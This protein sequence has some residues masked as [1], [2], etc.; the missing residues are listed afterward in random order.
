MLDHL[1][2]RS[3]ESL[4][5]LK[6]IGIQDSIS[7]LLPSAKRPSKLEGWLVKMSLIYSLIVPVA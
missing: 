3:E 2:A 7:S 4:R 6:L 5:H 1:P